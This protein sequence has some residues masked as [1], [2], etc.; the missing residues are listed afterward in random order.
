MLAQSRRSHLPIKASCIPSKSL[1]YASRLG[2]TNKYAY[3]Y[4]C[5][6]EFFEREMTMQEAKLMTLPL[7]DNMKHKQLDMM[8]VIPPYWEDPRYN[9]KPELMDRRCFIH[10]FLPVFY[11]MQ[12]DYYHTV[13]Y[14]DEDFEH[15]LPDPYSNMHFKN[16]RSPVIMQVVG[17][18]AVGIIVGF[19]T[20]GLKL[21][22]VH[23]A[24]QF[25]KKYGDPEM[26]GLAQ[27][28][29][30]F[31][32]GGSVEMQDQNLAYTPEGLKQIGNGIRMHLPGYHDMIC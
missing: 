27:H 31:E 29:A 12:E 24:H 16:K 7:N 6:D 28:N 4:A 5:E 18:V 11:N 20:L 19:P 2:M 8:E 21:P 13:G 32:Y 10:D 14:E 9:F 22:D 15:E 3:D 17:A 26:I 30:A 23:N 25:R 1:I